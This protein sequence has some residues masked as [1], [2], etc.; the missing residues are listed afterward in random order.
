MDSANTKKTA[1]VKITREGPLIITG[2]FT[3]TDINSC[4][5]QLDNE[6]E[7]WLCACGRTQKQPYCDG[8]HSK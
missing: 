7:V 5:L 3:I 4:V 2:N 1:E 6:Q 8:S